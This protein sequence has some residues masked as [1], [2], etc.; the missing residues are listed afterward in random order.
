[1]PNKHHARFGVKLWCLCDAETAYTTNFEVYKGA[2]DPQDRG[3]EGVT[4]SLVMRLMNDSNLLNCGHHLGL[5]NYFSSPKLFQDLFREN[6]TAT[7]TVRTNRKFLPQ[8]VVKAKLRNHQVCERRKG[9]LL[10]VAYKDG[11]KQPILLSTA[12]KGGFTRAA[13]ARGQEK[14]KPKCVVMYNKAMGGV[15]LSDARLYSYLAERRTMKWTTKVS[16]ALF[17][18]AILNSFILYNENTADRP[19]LSRYAFMVSVIEALTDDFRPPKVVRK[20]RSR[21]QIEADR[22]QPDAPIQPPDHAVVVPGPACG[23]DKLPVGKRR[24]C[25]NQHDG[26]VRTSWQCRRCNVGLCPTCYEPYHKR[27]RE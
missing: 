14:E 9:P 10:C 22:Q 1:M 25:V 12:A 23:L 8:Q 18:R 2:H 5:D 26:R 21:A 17:G 20:R 13:N 16:F 15:D 6:T 7:G 3:A 27:R 4:Y 11:G 19:K 24:N